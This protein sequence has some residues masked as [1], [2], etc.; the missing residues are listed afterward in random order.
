MAA[1]LRRVGLIGAG[2]IGRKR[3]ESMMNI[4]NFVGVYDSDARN[5]ERLAR[6]FDVSS[7]A[8][9]RDLLDEI[10]PGGLVFVSTPNGFLHDFAIEAL[11][12][13]C[14]IH[15]EKPGATSV[16]EAEVVA[17]HAKQQQR[18]VTVGYNHRFHPG[19]EMLAA[20]LKSGRFG[21]I[22]LIRSRYGH[23]GRKGYEK[24]WRLNS[25]LSGGGELID[26]GSHLIDLALALGGPIDLQFSSMPNLFWGGEVEDNAFV[27][28]RLDNGGKVWLH[29]SW[30][31]W[32]NLFCF[33][34][35]C[36]SAKLSVNG[37]GGSYGPEKYS[38]IVMGPDPG[39]A[40]VDSVEFPTFDESWRRELESILGI[41]DAGLPVASIDEAIN[42]LRLVEEAYALDHK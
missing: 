18:R 2:K 16:S 20:D 27:A 13:G 35:F 31:E 38:K 5:S 17:D 3:A 33:E 40:A 11:A 30:T 25:R 32:K 42:V 21:E 19:I 12:A 1:S 6:E 41:R 34:V 15:L 9:S 39:P 29:A 23:G 37:L 10:G 8:C 36:A 7:F 24:E 22:L 4:T 14:D 28:G 26:Q